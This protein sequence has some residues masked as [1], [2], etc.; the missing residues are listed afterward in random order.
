[1]STSSLQHDVSG[2]RQQ[3]VLG[4]RHSSIL[5]SLFIS[6]LS[7]FHLLICT[8]LHQTWEIPDIP[9]FT[10]GIFILFHSLFLLE[11]KHWICLAGHNVTP[12]SPC[13]LQDI[14]NGSDHPI[15]Y[16]IKILTPVWLQTTSA[17]ISI[18]STCV[19]NTPS[20]HSYYCVSSGGRGWSFVCP[21][22]T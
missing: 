15:L 14:P 20:S 18:W 11:F 7:C 10:H 16:Y 1:M 4:R 5:S 21:R 3:A 19:Q 22:T 8:N 9:F 12:C 6:S 2:D 17:H 13:E